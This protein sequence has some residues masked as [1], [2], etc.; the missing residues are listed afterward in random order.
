[1]KK[2]FCIFSVCCVL[3][4]S[5]LL[6]SHVLGQAVKT[7]QRPVHLTVLLNE[8]QIKV[9][10]YA[11][12]PSVVPF[13]GTYEE[14]LSSKKIIVPQSS[15]G[16]KDIIILN[17]DSDVNDTTSPKDLLKIVFLRNTANGQWIFVTAHKDI[18]NVWKAT[19]KDLVTVL[20]DVVTVL[21]EKGGERWEAHIGTRTSC[22]ES[23]GA[24]E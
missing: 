14:A 23:K 18:I 19:Q 10:C 21:Y 3:V 15:D 6:S 5:L 24:H 7:T 13:T 1:M 2:K 11:D 4:A 8:C 17:D 9:L 16:D 22:P 12:T 20:K